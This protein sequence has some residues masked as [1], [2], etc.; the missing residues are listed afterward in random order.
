MLVL[1]GAILLAACSH[2]PVEPATVEP[3]IA[4][5]AAAAGPQPEIIVV[6]AEPRSPRPATISPPLP[7][8]PGVAIVLTGRQPAYSTVAYE[9]S[10]LLDKFSIYDLSDKSQPA[11]TAFRLINDSDARAVVAIGVTAARFAV[12]QSALPVVFSQVFNYR[13]NGLITDKSRG[14]AALAPL[15][16]HLAAWKQG[17][18]E[19]K[20]V[21]AII[22]EGHDDLIAEAQ[23]A[24]DQ[25]NVELDIR[26]VTS[27]QEA[28]YQFR[29]MVADIDG[30][31]LFP[32]NRVLSTRSLKEILAQAQRRKVD[33][34]VSNDALL[35]LGASIS[36]SSV[37]ADVAATIV[38]VLRRIE[39]GQIESIPEITPLNA[40]QVVRR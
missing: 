6:R 38:T 16:A 1:L 30:F 26:I 23:A 31:W 35:P 19:L 7:E 4:L 10:Q 29:R 8:P 32:D 25:H 12:D 3:E 14:V 24:A 20:R 40:I 2:V 28:Q 22:G 34:A 36:I 39:A 9:L 33:V 18:P 13:N 27:D 5:P 15:D 37:A 17:K 11:D 21:G